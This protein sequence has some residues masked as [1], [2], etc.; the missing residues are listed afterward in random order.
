MQ[1]FYGFMAGAKEREVA[2]CAAAKFHLFQ[3]AISL[4]VS[5]NS[6]P[7][8]QIGGW[9]RAALCCDG[10]EGLGIVPSQPL[11]PSKLDPTCSCALAAAVGAPDGP[12]DAPPRDARP[13]TRPFATRQLTIAYCTAAHI[14]PRH[15][16]QNPFFHFCIQTSNEKAIWQISEKY[17]AL[18]LSRLVTGVAYARGSRSRLANAELLALAEFHI[19]CHGSLDAIYFYFCGQ[20]FG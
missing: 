12:S 17:F 9:A 8:E 10:R 19:Q 18:G 11:R 7:H 14:T 3:E 16:N 4:D 13:F 1:Q 5:G 6:A 20:K 15:D 2:S